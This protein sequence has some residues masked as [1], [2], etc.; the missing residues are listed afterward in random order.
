[1]PSLIVIHLIIP[2]IFNIVFNG[3]SEVLAIYYGTIWFSMV[4]DF[5]VPPLRQ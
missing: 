1:M 5:F 4:D 3:V 2:D